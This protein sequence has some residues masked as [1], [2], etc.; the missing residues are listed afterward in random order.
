MN[1]ATSSLP[2]RVSG[3]ARNAILQIHPSLRCNLFCAHCYSSSGPQARIELDPETVCGVISDAAGMGYRVV[4]VSG[5]EPMMYGG[6]EQVLAHAKSLGLRTTV[7]TNGFFNRPERLNRLRELVDVLAISLDGPPEIH[8]QIRG[9]AHAF[10]RLEAGLENVRQSGIPFGFI[11]TL[12]ERTW[13]HL[14]WVA[15]FAAENGASLFQIHPLE[16]AGRAADGMAGDAAEKDVLSKVYVLAFAIGAKYAGR[17]SVQV[18]LL[19]R[20]HLR[21]EPELIYAGE[22]ERAPE[23]TP[24]V[25][26]MGL[27][28]LEP[29]GAVVPVSFGFDRKYQLCNV[30]ERALAAAWPEYLAHGYPEFRALCHRVCDELCSPD[31]PIL[32][33]WHEVIVSRSHAVTAAA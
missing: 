6:L 8:N 5:G 27:L 10:E 2:G 13:G 31:A 16:L 17:M 3:P 22:L 28:V 11:H 24:P 15:D 14:L 21:E 20:E 1:S 30:R 4:S 7:T 18:D 12:T 29:D 33:N 32:S 25:A 19:Y 23:E 26:L 9:S